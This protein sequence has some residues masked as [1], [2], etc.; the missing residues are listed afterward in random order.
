MSANKSQAMANIQAR[1]DAAVAAKAARGQ[2]DLFGDVEQVP[3]A[4][5]VEI[6]QPPTAPVKEVAK[7]TGKR[8]DLLPVRHVERDFFLCDMFDYAMKDDGASMEAP[9]F[10]LSTKPDLAVWHWESKDGDR[11]LTVTPSVMGRATMFDKDVLIYVISQMTEALNIHEREG[12]RE[13]AKNR[14]VRFVVYDYLVTTNKPTGGQEYKRLE[15]TLER[16]RGTS[17]KTDIKTGGTRVKEGFGLIDSWSIVEK[18][19]DNERMI[20][21]EVTLSKWLFNAVQAHEVLTIHRNYFRL[22][23]PLE[24]RLYELARK[25]CGSQSSWTIGLELLREKCNAY[26]HIRAFRSQVL[27]IIAADI[28]P[29]YRMMYSR[30]KDQVTFYIRDPKKLVAAIA[31]GKSHLTKK[32]G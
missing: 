27:K 5:P 9:I 19:P 24:K 29:E 11:S 18:S 8:A 23:K 31:S 20:A 26:S 28:L 1:A 32:Y 4:S 21:I 7:I 30:E 15:A 3:S 10:T 2:T 17:I 25:H 22:R 12:G 14:T 16:L 6:E 13:D